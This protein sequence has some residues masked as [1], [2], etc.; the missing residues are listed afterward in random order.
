[1]NPVALPAALFVEGADQFEELERGGVDVGG[2]FGDS[3]GQARRGVLAPGIG[4]KACSGVLAWFG[5]GGL[6]GQFITV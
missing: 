5:H 4:K 3:V 6:Q 2:E 1:M